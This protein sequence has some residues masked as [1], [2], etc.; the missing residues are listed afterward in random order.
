VLVYGARETEVDETVKPTN[1][2]IQWRIDLEEETVSNKDVEG[3]VIRPG[4]VY[5]GAGGSSLPTLKITNQQFR[6]YSNQVYRP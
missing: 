1:K 5:G 4:F 3:V 6:L 2:I